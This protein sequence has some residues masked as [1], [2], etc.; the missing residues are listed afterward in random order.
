MGELGIWAGAAVL[1]LNFL[2]QN[3][4]F[5]GLTF[6]GLGQFC[7]ADRRSSEEISEANSAYLLTINSSLQ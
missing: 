5:R 6:V 3:L 2:H 4:K 7:L 1:G